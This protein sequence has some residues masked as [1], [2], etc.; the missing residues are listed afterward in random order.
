MKSAHPFARLLFTVICCTLFA[1]ASF[2]ASN[3]LSYPHGLAVDAKG[4]LWVANQLGGTNQTGNIL[5]FSPSYEESKRTITEQISLPSSVVFDPAGNL[6]VANFGTTNEGYVAEYTNGVPTGIQI[7]Q[8]ISNPGAMAIDGIGDIW[9]QNGEVNITVYGSVAFNTPPTTLLQT[10]NLAGPVQGVAISGNVAAYG[11]GIGTV[12]DAVEPVLALNQ[13]NGEYYP[14]FD[15][16]A[17]ASAGAGNVYVGNSN[18]IVDL[19]LAD[20]QSRTF[21]VLPFAP[22]GIAV[23]SVRGRVYISNGLGNAISVYSTAG[24][25]LHTIE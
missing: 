17:L 11:T 8:G 6:W 1:P 13:G 16:V 15:G 18:G 19:A 14:D 24:V 2:A 7:T 12:V 5:I 9:V 22:T 20:G 4:N 3:A 23:D 10:L 25:L 21:V